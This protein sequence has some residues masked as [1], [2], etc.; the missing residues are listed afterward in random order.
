MPAPVTLAALRS[1]VAAR[2]PPSPRSPGGLVPTGVPP[3]DA[4][5]GGGL[6]AGRLTELVV[7]PGAGGGQLIL[8]RLLQTTRA[9]RQRVALL[10]AADTFAPEAVP[11][12]ALRHLVW[13]RPPHLA[14][15]LPA[16]D[17]LVRDDHY[18]TIV[19]DLRGVPARALQAVPAA[20]WHRCRHAAA[21]H[22]GAVLV[23]TAFDLVPAVPWRLALTG[24]VTLAA[25]RQPLAERL[26]ALTVVT[27][28]GHLA[29]PEALA[30]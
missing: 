26:Q 22:S 11:A 25:R 19:L 10:D 14:A 3:L 30:G 17:V 13:V 18:A 29:I 2:F 21:D 20:W 15:A 12:D 4:A 23:L 28:R 6:P 8:L 16:A 27:R 7:P 24:A 1:L 9:A 5:L